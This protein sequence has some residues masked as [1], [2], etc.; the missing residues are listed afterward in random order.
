MEGNM[1]A[2]DGGL[3]RLLDLLT[4]RP[5]AN[6]LLKTLETDLLAKFKL[7]NAI[8]FT[9]DSHNIS[10]EIYSNNLTLEEKNNGGFNSVLAS[11]LPTSN[12]TS[13]TDS[14]LG[15]SSDD[16]FLIIPISNGKSLKGFILLE[17]DCAH[18]SAE[19][20]SLIEIMGKVCAFYLLSELPELKQSNSTEKIASQ[21]QFSA[22][23]L[24]IING[25]VEGKTN[26]ELAEDLGFSVST[27]RHETMDIFRLL[28]ASDRKE[29]AKIAQERSI[30]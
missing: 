22:R 26:H 14:K 10:K 15:R 18:L 19:D 11:I 29:A 12:L 25:F 20:L 2:L 28:G 16:N 27:V 24:Q 7:S 6:E 1:N 21:L 5:N 30:V 9:L 23:Q 3:S 8:I 17:L 13:L 4:V